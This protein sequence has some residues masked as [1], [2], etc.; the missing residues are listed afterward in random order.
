M[1]DASEPV[2]RERRSVA[3]YGPHPIDVHVGGRIRDRRMFLG[4]SQTKLGNELGL[5][6]QQVQKYEQGA[7]R[8]SASRLYLISQ[9]LDEPYQPTVNVR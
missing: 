7:N 3:R 9:V 5:T 1:N 6:F 4:M 8:V 2:R